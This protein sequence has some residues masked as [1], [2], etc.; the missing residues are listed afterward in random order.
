MCCLNFESLMFVSDQ[1]GGKI[2]SLFSL[3]LS[4]KGVNCIPLF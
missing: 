1:E 2:I 3:L 4:E